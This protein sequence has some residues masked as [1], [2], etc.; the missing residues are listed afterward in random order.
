VQ[1]HFLHHHIVHHLDHVRERSKPLLTAIVGVTARFC[2]TDIASRCLNHL[3]TILSRAVFAGESDIHLVQALLL[4]IYWRTPGDKSS[5]MKTGIAVRMSLALG[6]HHCFSDSFTNDFSD[7]R[8]LLVSI[9]RYTRVCYP[10]AV[11]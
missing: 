5:W 1:I 4:A 2:A 9:Q 6:L 10:I 8:E 3:D 11:F 7:P